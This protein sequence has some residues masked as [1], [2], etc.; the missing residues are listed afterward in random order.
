MAD[1]ISTRDVNDPLDRI[2]KTLGRAIDAVTGAPDIMSGLSAGAKELY[3]GRMNAAYDVLQ[4]LG[5][6]PATL[7]EYTGE[8]AVG[9]LRYLAG[10]E[11]A[12]NVPVTSRSGEAHTMSDTLAGDLRET[13]IGAAAKAVGDVGTKVGETLGEV[14]E[15]AGEDL[16]ELGG[17]IADAV[18]D[19]MKEALSGLGKAAELGALGQVWGMVNSAASHPLTVAQDTIGALGNIDNL[20]NI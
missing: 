13:P 11:A 18:P 4:A 8:S 12:A 17:K 19:E 7:P 15:K 20:K 1:D 6:D 2:G 9:N 3:A 14:G 10:D 5:A 16:G